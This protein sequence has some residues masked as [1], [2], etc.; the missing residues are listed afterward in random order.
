[1]PKLSLKN[2]RIEPQLHAARPLQTIRELSSCEDF[3]ASVNRLP[4]LLNSLLSTMIPDCRNSR[5]PHGG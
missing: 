3:R 5:R 1:M 4:H 2:F